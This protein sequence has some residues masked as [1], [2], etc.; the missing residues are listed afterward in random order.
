M[1]INGNLN[2]I[3]DFIELP[4]SIQHANG[5]YIYCNNHFLTLVGKDRHEVISNTPENLFTMSVAKT[6]NAADDYLHKSNKN[7][8]TY[9]TRCHD[10]H[11]HPRISR[12]NKTAIRDGNE[13]VCGFIT[14][15]LVKSESTCLVDKLTN[16]EVLVL[17]QI[18]RGLA[19]KSIA[20]LLGISPHTVTGYMKSIYL[21]LEV[22]S[23]SQAQL[24]AGLYS[25]AIAFRVAEEKTIDIFKLSEE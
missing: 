13:S 10:V 6:H 24:K 21:K 4:L 18:A 9:E 22:T 20:K 1:V 2:H 19:V 23:R 8:L 12:V 7:T 15:T 5:A 17:E 16:R 25:C 11:P 3:F 14:I